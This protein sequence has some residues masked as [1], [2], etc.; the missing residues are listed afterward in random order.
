MTD[1]LPPAR[2]LLVDDIEENLIALEALLR[3][4]D[5]QCVCVHSGREA[6]E[7]LL[8]QEFALALLDVNM[9]EMDGFQLAE[10][11]R[12]MQRTRTIP[13]VFVTAAAYDPQRMFQGYD[14]GAIDFLTKPIEPKILLSKVRT[15]IE[16]HDHKRRLA[17]ELAHVEQVTKQLAESLR[18]HEMFVAAL[19]HD[20]RTP[21]NSISLG[22]NLLTAGP[23]TTVQA[24]VVK[25]VDGAVSRISTMLD[26]LYDL[27]RTR[28]GD[29]IPLQTAVGNLV[30]ISEGVIRE[31]ELRQADAKLAVH[32]TGDPVGMWDVTRI[33]RVVA[34]LVTNAITHGAKGGRIDLE[35]DGTHEDEVRLVVS[36]EGAI[37]SELIGTIFE[38]FRRGERSGQGL[39]LGLYIVREIARAHRGTVEV[40]STPAAGTRFEVKLPRRVPTD[41]AAD[42]S[43]AA[44]AAT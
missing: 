16:L 8:S 39:G 15:F 38:P 42:V 36:N 2:V 18:L 22:M 32:V 6:L 14:A 24:N 4:M 34:N 31:A 41:P 3:R 44:P 12:G 7:Q 1:V 40:V 30:E 23:L 9:P 37:P 21:L 26:Q 27:A 5:I 11:M 19:N 43:G 25:R 20:L 10:L 13:I 28:V 35:I 17:Q 33:T 29:G